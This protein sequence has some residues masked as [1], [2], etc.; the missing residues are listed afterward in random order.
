MKRTLLALALASAASLP[1]AAQSAD[2]ADKLV[3]RVNGKEFTA[4]D[5]DAQ[6]ARIDPKMQEQYLARAGGKRV[7]LENYLAKYLL[8]QEAI[9]S[10][11]AAK[12]N[13]PAELDPKAESELFDRYVREVL[14]APLITEEMMRDAY[15][16]HRDQFRVP[17]QARFRTI[18]ALKLD[19]PEQAR[20]KVAQAMV[21]IFSARATIAKSVPAEQAMAALAAKFSEVAT[22]ASDHE[23]AKTGGEL[24]WVALHTVDP[25]IG[26]AARTM[27]PGTI[28]GVLE[29]GDAYQIIL[30]DEYR[31]ADVE[32][33]ETA[34]DALREFVMA[35]QARHV[36]EAVQKKSAELRSTGKVEVFAENIR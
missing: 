2:D 36:M 22:R 12:I 16:Q 26:N 30:V 1:L 5:L 15:T 33:Y 28:S 24:G 34:K 8:V 29:S 25:R 10:G 35:R 3:A 6:W 7:F 32:T 14:A 18:R 4:R 20:N 21:E 19:N 13:A 9:R 17:E 23:S 31:G 27:K 11:F